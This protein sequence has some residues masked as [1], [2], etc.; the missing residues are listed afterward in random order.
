[1]NTIAECADTTLRAH[2][3]PALRLSELNALIAPKVDRS[4]T[5]R[6]LRSVLEAH[7]ERFRLLNSWDEPWRSPSPD[8]GS[9]GDAWVVSVDLPDGLALDAPRAVLR[10]RESVRWIARSV[11]GRSRVEVSRW[12]AIALSERAAR[13]A[14]ARRAA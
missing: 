4:M 1:M 12:Y 3:H 13:E 11:D 9:V 14:V 2:P 7:P 8:S 5:P 10:L 6:R